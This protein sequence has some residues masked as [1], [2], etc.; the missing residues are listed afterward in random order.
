MKSKSKNLII[1]NEFGQYTGQQIE[2]AIHE[3]CPQMF[4]CE[5]NEK[6]VSLLGFKRDPS[7][8]IN[9]AGQP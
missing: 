5:E 4:P 8:D 2:D 3:I 6:E 9:L 7:T 1:I